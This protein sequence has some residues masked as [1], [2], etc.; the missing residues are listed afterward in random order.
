MI[1]EALNVYYNLAVSKRDLKSLL[2]IEKIFLV[3]QVVVFFKNCPQRAEQPHET[4]V[5]LHIS[6]DNSPKKR[7][8]KIKQLIIALQKIPFPL[9]QIP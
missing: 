6:K 1:L 4:Y 9:N 5:S 7:R 2:K 3:L 8:T